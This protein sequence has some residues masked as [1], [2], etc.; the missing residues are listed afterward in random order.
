MNTIR[1]L[2]VVILLLCCVAVSAQTD[3]IVVGQVLS[4]HD[5]Q[6]IEG[7]IVGFDQTSITTT[8]NAEGYFLLKSASKQSAIRV[9]MFGFET[10]RVKL[11]KNQRDQ[12]INIILK[13][14]DLSLDE[15]AI[16][17][18]KRIIDR[19]IAQFDK[20]R[21]QNN[22]S[23]QFGFIADKEQNTR[24]YFDNINP[25][26]LNNSILAELK[27]STIIS[28][29][30][31]TIILP[32]HFSHNI[33]R[34][35]RLKDSTK[36]E[37][38][39]EYSNTLEMIGYE[40]IEHLLAIYT[41]KIDF[42]ENQILFLK[43]SFPSPIAKI[44]TFFYNY[45]V[46]DSITKDSAICYYVVFEP[47]NK[48]DL[49]FKGSVLI[50]AQ[51]FALMS[52]NMTILNS[53][54]IN[55]VKDFHIKQSF[56]KTNKNQYFYKKSNQYVSLK[57]DFGFSLDTNNM[58]VVIDRDEEYG[59]LHSISDSINM[60]T[61]KQDIIGGQDMFYT[62][63][64]T[65]NNTNIQQVTRTFTDIAING[66]IHWGKID[67]GNIYSFV[68]YNP[69]EGF[70][71]TFALRT[72][73]MFSERL[74]VGGYLGYGL[75]DKKTKYGTSL[76]LFLDTTQNHTFS[77]S[78][79]NDVYRLGYDFRELTNEKLMSGSENI[80]TSFS[81]GQ[82]YDKLLRNQNIIMN[83]TYD[84]AILKASFTPSL[85]MLYANHLVGFRHD[86]QQID[87]VTVFTLNAMLRFSFGRKYI[88]KRFRRLYMPTNYPIL[89]LFADAGAYSIDSI[90]YHKYAKLMFAIRQ[91]VPTVFGKINYSLSATKIFGG[92]PYVLLEQPLTM[93][94]I[95]SNKYNFNLLNQSEFFAD[96]YASLFLRYYT[97][98][99]FFN[100]IP[101]VKELLL[102]ETAFINM[103]WGYM[104]SKHSKVL[105]MPITSSLQTPYVE[106][107]VGI[108]NILRI[109]SL[110]SVWRLTHRQDHNAVNW[111]VR[112]R[113]Y[114]DF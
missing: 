74:M 34:E 78:Y 49:A 96:T 77:L 88:Q 63:I 51:S 83:Y 106:A 107:G 85:S 19:I 86:D 54:N 39:K 22:P 91:V 18:S 66:Y 8:T 15:V 17:S 21:E 29:H 11:N 10:K 3:I 45:A 26:L 62:K 16:S 31:S 20:R 67:F 13:K 111:G 98:G 24:L 4:D 30:D 97:N 93:Q 57:N 61:K 69:L 27:S 6:P 108:T 75:S 2:I 41:P 104:D 40:A 80:F 112:L 43:K 109:L 114:V 47:K 99:L 58:L 68:R 81:W 46:S 35:T 56:V 110:E 44:G 42:Y 102:R 76:Q 48:K 25:K 7:A 53:A 113:F 82:I 73:K 1:T 87:A 50:N 64:D 70:R 95:W 55:F 105:T 90:G 60:P 37:N 94:G 14:E 89:T 38:I 52:I 36:R 59:S 84:N 65:L 72:S 92:V 71:P 32:I 79:N 28:Y 5:H 9:E 103:A 12:S 23:N 33:E 100:K 101:I